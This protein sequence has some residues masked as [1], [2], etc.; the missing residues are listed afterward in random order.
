MFSVERQMSLEAQA[1]H[2][3]W[4][5]ETEPVREGFMDDIRGRDDR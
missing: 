4:L 1:G 2:Q 5:A 3:E